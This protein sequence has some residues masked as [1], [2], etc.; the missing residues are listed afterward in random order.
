MLKCFAVFFYMYHRTHSKRSGQHLHG[1]SLLQ[2][3][4][5]NSTLCQLLWQVIN[6]WHC[7]ALLKMHKMQRNP[8]QDG[9]RWSAVPRLG[10]AGWW[11]I[12]Q[13]IERRPGPVLAHCLRLLEE[14]GFEGRRGQEW[15]GRKA[16]LRQHKQG[17][18]E[19]RGEMQQDLPVAW[20]KSVGHWHV[21]S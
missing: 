10:V 3:P 5:W 18:W 8:Y 6:Y 7:I 15:P 13:T 21:W 17:R 20:Y 4:N 14:S 1:I 19:W 16:V 2:S 9:S 11:Y 12:T